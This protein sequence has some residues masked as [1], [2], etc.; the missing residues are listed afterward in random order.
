[1]NQSRGFRRFSSQ[2][3]VRMCVCCRKRFI[4]SKLFRLKINNARIGLFDGSGRSFYLCEECIDN[5]KIIGSL[6]KLKNAP[7]DKNIIKEQIEEIRIQ[8]QKL[9]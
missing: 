7:K 9:D 1:M 3:A 6:T 2:N 8:W 5:N 4:Q